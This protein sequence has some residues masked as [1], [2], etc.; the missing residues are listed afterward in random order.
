[1]S[2]AHAAQALKAAKEVKPA[3]IASAAASESGSAAGGPL[4]R[5]NTDENP[6]DAHVCTSVPLDST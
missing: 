4:H 3:G 1:M 2:P 5:Q 6:L